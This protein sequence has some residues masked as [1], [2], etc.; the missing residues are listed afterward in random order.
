M[1]RL[2]VVARNSYGGLQLHVSASLIFGLLI[3][4][5]ICHAAEVAYSAKSL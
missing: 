1:Y 3:T 2:C 4:I 5:L